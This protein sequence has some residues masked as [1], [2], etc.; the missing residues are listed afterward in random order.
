MGSFVYIARDLTGGQKKG[1][2]RGAS[3]HDV[4][5]WLR[6]Q[7]LIPLEIRPIFSALTLKRRRSNHKRAK[8][9][10]IAS[11]CW[12]LATMVE[13]GV[14]VTEAIDTILEDIESASFKETLLAVSERIKRGESFSSSVSKFPRVFSKLF[15]GM[16]VVGETAGS[17]PTILRRLGDYFD[18]RDKFA[19]KVK[20]AT[21]YPIFVVLFVA[22][23]LTF[24]VAVIIPK[25]RVIFAQFGG[26]LPAFTMAFL[27]FYDIVAANVVLIVISLISV[28]VLAVAY[29]RTRTGHARLSRLA[30]CVP[31][32]GKLISMAFVAT[33]CRTMATLLSTGVSIIEAFDILAET[34]N[35]DVIRSAVRRSKEHI[36][37]GSSISLATAAAGFFPNM[38][39]KMIQVGEKSGSLPRVL[40]RAGVYYERRVDARITTMIDL[41]G[42]ALI[43]VIGA[44]V[45]VVVIAL[46]LPI[47]N[48]SGT[49]RVQ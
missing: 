48:M 38:V 44:I 43:V 40:D 41:L 24:M 32:F 22:F 16:I 34:S 17:L 42:P 36:I 12:Q 10:Q 15:C 19:R 6:H 46:Y 25:F 45:A 26:E 3:L 33:F 1:L 37:A 20:S 18:Q 29:G 9:V 35:N 28:I 14:P 31:F 8:T 30:L 27:N 11:F 4:N 13:G 23:V 39:A 21:A 2:K 7:G 47:F 49:M 5:L